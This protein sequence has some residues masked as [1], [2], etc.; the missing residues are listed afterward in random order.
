MDLTK[1]D[2]VTILQYYNLPYQN[3]A[4]GEMKSACERLLAEKLCR[5]IKKVKNIKSE[6]SRIAICKNSIFKK[7]NLNMF[8]FTCKKRIGLLSKKNT[9]KKLV[10]NRR[11]RF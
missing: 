2:Y 3:M 8:G 9:R 11:I 1:K 4:K 6:K 5:C 10:K 7:R